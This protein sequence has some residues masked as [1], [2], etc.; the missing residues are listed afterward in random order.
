MSM[1]GPILS[2]ELINLKADANQSRRHF[3]R[4]IHRRMSGHQMES[5]ELSTLLNVNME[6][7]NSKSALIKALVKIS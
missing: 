4:Q 2:E 6:V 5:T 3:R 7:Y 1:D